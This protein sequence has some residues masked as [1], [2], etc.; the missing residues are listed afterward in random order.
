MHRCA[1]YHRWT[2][3]LPLNSTNSSSHHPSAQWHHSDSTI[4]VQTYFQEHKLRYS[5]TSKRRANA[6]ENHQFG[7]LS[8]HTPNS[9]PTAPRFHRLPYYCTVLEALPGTVTKFAQDR[10]TTKAAQH[11]P[12]ELNSDLSACFRI[13]LKVNFSRSAYKY[14]PPW[15]FVPRCHIP[16]SLAAHIRR[17]Q[18]NMVICNIRNHLQPSTHRHLGRRMIAPERIIRVYLK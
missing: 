2:A 9:V 7:S 17:R 12:A 3:Q 16:S 14:P 4:T 11:H 13:K 18:K 5:T 1:R 15:L 6:F 10:F 8:T